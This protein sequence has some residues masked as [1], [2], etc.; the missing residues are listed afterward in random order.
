MGRIKTRKVKAITMDLLEQHKESFGT[1]FTENKKQ[2]S[3]L[4]GVS[5]KK[6]RNIIAGYTTRLMKSESK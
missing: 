3:A 5:S 4:T 1:D 6:L 2:V